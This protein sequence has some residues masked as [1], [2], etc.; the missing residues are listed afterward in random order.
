[1]PR[2]EYGTKTVKLL[3]TL[4]NEWASYSGEAPMH[5]DLL[6]TSADANKEI[7]NMKLYS[8]CI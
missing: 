5:V 3:N 1:M 7:I 2:L 6:N 4:H 8:V